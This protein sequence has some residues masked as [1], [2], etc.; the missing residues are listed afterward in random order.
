M[1]WIIRELFFSLTHYRRDTRP[2]V[3]TSVSDSVAVWLLAAR[4]VTRNCD[5]AHHM[6][7][8]FTYLP[9]IALS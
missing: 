2:T 8:S 6:Y 9:L 5:M 4:A 3:L 7:V 1:F